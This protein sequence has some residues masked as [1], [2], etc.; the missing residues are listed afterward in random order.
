MFKNNLGDLVAAQVREK[1]RMK[2]QL[3]NYEGV[4]AQ[5]KGKEEIEM[6]STQQL[7]SADV[8][9]VDQ[10]VSTDDVVRAGTSNQDQGVDNNIDKDSEDSKKANFFDFGFLQSKFIKNIFCCLKENQQ[11]GKIFL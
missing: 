7:E 1:I 9:T 5:I 8:K 3:N 11:I 10:D 6:V 2:K 4:V